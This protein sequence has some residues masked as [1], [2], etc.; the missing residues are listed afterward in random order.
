MAVALKAI[1]IKFKTIFSTRQI[2]FRSCDILEPRE[3]VAFSLS[4]RYIFLIAVIHLL[5]AGVRLLAVLILILNSIPPYVLHF[6]IIKPVLVQPLTAAVAE[7]LVFT[8]HSGSALW[9]PWKIRTPLKRIYFFHSHRQSVSRG[10]QKLIQYPCGQYIP[11][12]VI[13]KPI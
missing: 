5:T 4:W 10:E 9:T 6:T 11:I 2:L 3:I 1:S 8:F 7:A 12:S 13:I